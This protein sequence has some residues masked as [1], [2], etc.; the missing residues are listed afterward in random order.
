MS[1]NDIAEP[2]GLKTLPAAPAAQDDAFACFTDHQWYCH[3][4]HQTVYFA[5]FL[6]ATPDR[7]GL[8]DLAE[9]VAGHIPELGALYQGL[10]GTPLSREA[11]GRIVSI[12]ETD[13]LDA[14][15]DRW[16]MS[17]ADVFAR[18]DLPMLR[19]HAAIRRGGA[20]AAG[21]RGALLVV[22]THSLFEGADSALLSRSQ[23]T[24]HGTLSAP[25]QDYSLLRR[26]AYGATAALLGPAQ[27]LAALA[28]APR[29]TDKT[30]KS[31]VFRR[32]QLRR[33]A[34]KLG[35]RQR[36]L[37][38]ALSLYALNQGGKGYSRK[39]ISATY[40][41]LDMPGRAGSEGAY[42]RH[43]VTEAGFR[44]DDDFLSFA[45][46]IEAELN[47][48]EKSDKRATQGLLHAVFGAH[49]VMRRWLPFLYS[50]RI[51]RFA[52]LYQVNLSVTPPHRLQGPLTRNMVEPVHAG[53][54]HPG[55]DMCIFVPGRK[56]VTFNFALGP[57]VIGQVDAI[58]GLL[59]RLDAEPER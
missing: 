47:R 42:F 5:S 16:D 21:R 36:S 8:I 50:D 17:G 9:D 22:S 35:L 32:E 46:N 38:F 51:F 18:N 58:P 40:A 53:S 45:R 49:R 3:Q 56:T 7:D 1:V 29:R 2:V 33:V 20:D 12:E 43:W 15:P 55:L 37:M 27:L 48:L 19:I 54:Y 57:K 23:S 30:C 14:Y 52:G 10:T 44:V 41:N 6:T 4:A 39:K 25:T 11:L 34:A 24:G 28:V 59:D 31:L 26:I 13:E